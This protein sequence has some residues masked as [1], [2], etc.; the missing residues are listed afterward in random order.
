[1]QLTRATS[2]SLPIVGQKEMLMNMGDRDILRPSIVISVDVRVSSLHRK[3]KRFFISFVCPILKSEAT[4]RRG[5]SLSSAMQTVL[6]CEFMATRTEN[7]VD[8][9]VSDKEPLR[10]SH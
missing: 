5:K 6:S 4:W 7:Q 2:P 1:M 10:M 3:Q 8:L 9:I